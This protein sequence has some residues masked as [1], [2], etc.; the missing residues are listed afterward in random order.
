M[1]TSRTS[2]RIAI[3]GRRL[4][5]GRDHAPRSQGRCITPMAIYRHYKFAGRAEEK[6]RVVVEGRPEERAGCSWGSDSRAA[7]VDRHGLVKL[8]L[9]R[10]F[11]LLPLFLG[12]FLHFLPLLLL[13]RREHVID[14]GLKRCVDLLGL[15]LLLILR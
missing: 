1:A 2:R 7:G 13:I 12:L 6:I 11:T 5:E 3:A 15:G 4:L 10:G 8:V 9:R 14:L